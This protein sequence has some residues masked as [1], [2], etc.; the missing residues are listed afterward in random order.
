MRLIHYAYEGRAP[1]GHTCEYCAEAIAQ[2]E[3]A[4]TTQFHYYCAVRMVTGSADCLSRGNHKHGT[5]LPDD[6]SLSKREAALAAY[7]VW[8][9]RNDA[10][11]GGHFRPVS[12]KFP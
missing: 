9:A 8:K 12:I 2:G 7:K 6:P 1:S 10:L 3:L 4:T 5:C 11:A